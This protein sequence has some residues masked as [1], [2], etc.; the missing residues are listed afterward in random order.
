MSAL[1]NLG[2]KAV[3]GS[4]KSI[5]GK[6]SIFRK[7]Y[8]P[9]R[10]TFS[11]VWLSQN[12]FYGKLI[13]VFGSFKHFYRKCIKFGKRNKTQQK[14]MNQIRRR[15]RWDRA[16][17]AT[18]SGGEVDDRPTSGAR[19]TSVLVER[20]ARSMTAPRDL[21]DRAAR[22]RGAIVGRAARFGLSLLSLSLWSGLSLFSFSLWSG[23]S[24]LSLFLSLFPEMIWRENE[25]A[26][27][28]PG[29]RWKYW[30]IG[31]H[32]LE[33]IIFRDSQTCGFGGKWFPE[34]IF[35]QNKR[36]LKWKF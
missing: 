2:P 7:C 1:N 16:V 19:P 28:F 36:T 13:S 34:I 27:S 11:C 8:F 30:S 33:N 26:K 15:R 25:G 3:F 4:R 21:V 18:A 10:K 35:T 14:K 32:F 6:Y 31:S 24:L 22:R 23:L 20:A 5:S 9:E 12:S 29:Q 17:K